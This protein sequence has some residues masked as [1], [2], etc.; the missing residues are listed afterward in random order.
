LNYQVRRDVTVSLTFVQGTSLVV[1]TSQPQFASTL[2]G[3][4]AYQAMQALRLTGFGSIER[5]APIN[6]I[7]SSDATLNYAV[8]FTATYQLRAWLVAYL[9]YQFTL[10]EQ[11]SGPNITENQVTVGLTFSYPFLF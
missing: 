9:T 6:D 3:S 7:T 4:V 5:V 8:G 11:V 1:G 10:Q 2:T